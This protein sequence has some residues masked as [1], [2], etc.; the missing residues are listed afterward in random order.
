MAIEHSAK[1]HKILRSD[2]PDFGR[3]SEMDLFEKGFDWRKDDKGLVYLDLD[4]VRLEVYKWLYRKNPRNADHLS[5]VY[6]ER[7]LAAL[8][9]KIP[10]VRGVWHPDNHPLGTKLRHLDNNHFYKSLDTDTLLQVLHR[11]ERGLRV[12]YEEKLGIPLPSIVVNE[13]KP[14]VSLLISLS[15]E[16]SQEEISNAGRSLKACEVYALIT[17]FVSIGK[18]GLLKLGVEINQSQWNGLKKAEKIVV[19]SKGELKEPQALASLYPKL[20]GI[21]RDNINSITDNPKVP[22][23]T[24]IVDILEGKTSEVIRKILSARFEI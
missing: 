1:T 4:S 23:A 20:L 17:K 19:G 22:G 12:L 13:D 6:L 8:S 9:E 21:S 5:R 10:I 3:D 24:T 14:R 2:F 15:K 16:P 18:E 7:D 11:D